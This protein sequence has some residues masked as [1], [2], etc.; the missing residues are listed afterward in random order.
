MSLRAGKQ[1][2][3]YVVD[4]VLARGGMGVVWRARDT[5][6]N[7]PVA[8]KVIANDLL[9]N[10][11]FRARIRDEA[12]RHGRLNHPGIVPI[13]DVF[14]AEN[15]TC[16]V[17]ALIEGTSLDRLLDSRENGRLEVP[18][19][20]RIAGDILES[21]DYAHQQ[22]IIHRDVKPSNVLLDRSGK[23]MLIDFGI[24]LAVGEE[25]RT[26]TGQMIGTPHYMSPEQITHP[27]KLDHRSD[28]YSVGC[29]VYEMLTGHPPFVKG[30]NGVGNT[31][32]SIHEAHV[33]LS[34]VSA[35]K[36]VPSL[37]VAL[38]DILMAALEKDPSRRIPGCGEFLRQLKRVN[39]VPRRDAVQPPRFNIRHPLVKWA[40]IILILTLLVA[41]LIWL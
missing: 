29:V 35:L 16:I 34:P 4:E 38:D 31:D 14:E 3:S 26:R 15:D 41:A 23:A 19:A 7:R 30:R 32:F 18:E 8:I 33:K 27:R 1:I 6:R 2:R 13:L 20:L 9:L 5:V 12:E 40:F 21:L 17:M 22:G 28:V 24:A 11:E 36:E 39:E 10:P 25:R 37:P